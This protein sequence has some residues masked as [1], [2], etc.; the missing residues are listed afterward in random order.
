MTET[1]SKIL[2]IEDDEDTCHLLT[3]VFK[4]V[5]CEVESCSQTKCL[6]LIHEETFSAII[7]DN[8]F[9][10]LSGIEICQEIRSFDQITPVIF[11]SGE[12]RQA[13]IDKALATGAN[14]YLIK[15]N[16]FEKLVPTTIKLIEH[17]K[18]QTKKE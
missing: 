17:S 11:L 10:G 16:D 5:D 9:D 8:Y 12:A 14:A 6:K 4:Q 13:E 7:L 2:C 15:P 18:R 1:K 3:Y